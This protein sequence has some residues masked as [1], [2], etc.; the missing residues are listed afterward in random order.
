MNKKKQTLKDVWLVDLIP[1]EKV[2]KGLKLI[3]MLNQR[4][5]FAACT[6]KDQLFVIGGLRKYIKNKK[7]V[8]MLD[9]NLSH[10]W[11]KTSALNHAR[12]FATAVA[13]QNADAIYI[14]GGSFLEKYNPV[15][16][17]SIEKYSQVLDSWTVLEV[18]MHTGIN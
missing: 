18:R 2:A 17:N 16:L 5:G 1:N 13:D 6:L 4:N 3:S 12:C 15:H 9:L 8:E 7:T 11:Q 10:A 14:F